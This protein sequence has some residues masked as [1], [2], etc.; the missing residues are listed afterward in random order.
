M[1]LRRVLSFI[2][3]NAYRNVQPLDLFREEQTNPITPNL[4][5]QQ[6]ASVGENQFFHITFSQYRNL[7]RRSPIQLPKLLDLIRDSEEFDAFRAELLRVPIE[8]EG[9]VNLIEDLNDLVE[10]I[11]QMRNCVAHNRRP[12]RRTR[13]SYANAYSNLDDRLDRYLE[14]LRTDRGP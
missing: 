4:T 12:S 11:E 5:E 9:D 3:L 1:K 13:T 14:N 6:M 8:N 2:Y 10:P 7:N